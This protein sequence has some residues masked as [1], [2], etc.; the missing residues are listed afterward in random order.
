MSCRLRPLSSL[1]SLMSFKLQHC[2]GIRK[3]DLLSHLIRLECLDMCGCANLQGPSITSLQ[4][5][6]ALR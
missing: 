4:V 5:L 6:T 2:Q 3:A 1:T